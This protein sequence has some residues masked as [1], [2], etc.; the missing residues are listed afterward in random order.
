MEM[1][2]PATFYVL[3]DAVTAR[4]RHSEDKSQ[5]ELAV[6]TVSQQPVPDLA[7]RCFLSPLPQTGHRAGACC[8]DQ[9]H[10]CIQLLSSSCCLLLL[11]AVSQ[12]GVLS[13]IW[14][15]SWETSF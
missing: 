6:V 2:G 3:I 9:L 1:L 14:P 13:T 4:L 7:F 12:T 10:G 15:H 8:P 5:A 11:S